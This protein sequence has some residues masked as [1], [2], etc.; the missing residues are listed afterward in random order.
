MLE[1]GHSS[2][3]ADEALRRARQAG[4][5]DDRALALDHV[6]VRSAGRGLGRARLMRE[7]NERGVDAALARDAWQRAVDEHGVDEQALLRERIAR[8]LGPRPTA[9]AL[10]RVYNAMLRAGFEPSDVRSALGPYLSSAGVDD[11]DEGSFESAEPH[12]RNGI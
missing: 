7:L 10:R 12:E 2:L 4:Y 3:D 5:I 9:A 1:R 8:K 11:D 6:L